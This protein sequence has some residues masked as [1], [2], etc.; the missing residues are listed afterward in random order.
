MGKAS[1][2]RTVRTSDTRSAPAPFVSRPFQ[3]LPSETEWVAL[4]ELVPAATAP[5]AFAAGRAPEGGS[6]P[7]D[8]AGAPATAT[9]ATVLPLAWPALHRTGGGI[10]VATQSGPASGDASRDLA[11]ALLL[12]AAADEGVAISMVPTP[13]VDSPRLQ[14]LLDLDVAFD[15]TVHDGFQFW[16]GDAELDTEGQ[17]SLERANESV[18]PT[19][20]VEGVT[21]AYWCLINGRS[22]VRWVLPHDEDVA[23]D[24]LARVMAS[25]ESLLVDGSRLL[26]AFRASGLIVPV[27]EVPGDREASDF[28]EGTVAMGRRLDAAVASADPLDAAERRARAG[29]VNRQ[30]T[31]R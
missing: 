7:S 30:V 4:R 25:D 16:V 10:F 2:R 31:L 13:T 8:A 22:Y 26:G 17:E 18:I 15:V 5:I 21:S 27:W 1:K 6:G 20:R 23:T 11:A 24:A 12:A 19:A 9:V 3:G 29:L 28:T 14:D